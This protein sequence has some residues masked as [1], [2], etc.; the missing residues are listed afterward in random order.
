MGGWTF[1]MIENGWR[2]F[3]GRKSSY[4][5]VVIRDQT[6]GHSNPTNRRTILTRT[7]WFLGH[8]K[9]WNRTKSKKGT[10]YCPI[11]PKLLAWYFTHFARFRAS[12]T[13]VS[14]FLWLV[15]SSN[16]QFFV[17]SGS[18]VVYFPSDFAEFFFHFVRAEFSRTIE[19]NLSRYMIIIR[20]SHFN[21][22]EWE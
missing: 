17:E 22:L 4:C 11:V 8:S 20:I 18:R 16:H 5:D 9:G 7:V 3:A 21:N 19:E 13:T 10:S 1:E 6:I 14:T 2:I 15:C 12:I